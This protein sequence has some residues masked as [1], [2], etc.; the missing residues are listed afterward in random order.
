MQPPSSSGARPLDHVRILLVDDDDDIRD[1]IA[2]VLTLHGAAVTTAQTGNEAL[3]AF[4]REPTDLVLSDLWMPDGDGF[5]LIR[6]IRS[7]EPS[8]GGLTPAIALSAA[9]HMHAAMLAGYHAFIAKPFDVAKVLAIV[10]D[11]TRTDGSVRLVAPWT[12]RAV[13]RGELVISLHDDLR[14]PDM[15]CLMKALFSHLE[16]GPVDIVVD[17]RQLATFSPSVGSVGERSLWSHRQRIRSL[18]VIGGSTGARLIS[19]CACRVLGIPYQEDA[20]P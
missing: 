14:R 4:L 5:E 17:L 2:D 8:A 16:D 9:E 1:C 7:R 18:R 6:R 11:F 15:V 12:I 19:A 10:E 3:Q 20:H 13:G